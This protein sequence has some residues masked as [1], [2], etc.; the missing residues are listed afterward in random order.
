MDLDKF[1]ELG[2]TPTTKFGTGPLTVQQSLGSFDDLWYAVT[3]RRARW[4][5][6]MGDYAGSELFILDGGSLL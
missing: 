5:D 4:M 2:M 6:L 1:D 3:Y